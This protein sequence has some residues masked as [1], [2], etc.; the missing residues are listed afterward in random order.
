MLT[1]TQFAA[2]M[3]VSRQY[4]HKLLMQRR[5]KGARKV[6]HPGMR[7]GFLWMIPKAAKIA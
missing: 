2:R 5:I 6:P 7:D 3:G 1:M 4:V